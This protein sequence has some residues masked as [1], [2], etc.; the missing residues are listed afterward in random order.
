MKDHEIAQVVN[1]LRDIGV[2]YGGAQQLRER[3]TSLVT[4][5]FHKLTTNSVASV[6]NVVCR[7]IP[8]GYTLYLEME[9][10]YGGIMMTLANGNELDLDD[11]N[12]DTETT[13][14]EKLKQAVEIAQAMER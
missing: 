6:A 9:N 10:G 14:A 4:P 13:L 2:K 3:I 8:S 12:S 5:I 7:D 11:I 1:K